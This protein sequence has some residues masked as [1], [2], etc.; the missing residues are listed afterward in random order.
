LK[1]KAARKGDLLSEEYAF[2]PGERET[3]SAHSHPEYQIGLGVEM[4][5]RY[6]YRGR[7]MTAPPMTLYLIHSGVTHDR[8]TE[9]SFEK[10]CSHRIL[11]AAPELI[12]G[13]AREVGWRSSELPFFP[14]FTINDA[15]L[16]NKFVALHRDAHSDCDR[17]AFDVAQTRFLAHLVRSFSNLG[18]KDKKVKIPPKAIK[19]V[20][21]YLDANFANAISLADLAR[22]GQVSKYHLCRTF[23]ES[24]GVSLHVYQNHLRLDRAKRL[25][26]QKRSI[27]DVAYELGFYD[28]SHFGRYFRNF[29]GVTPRMYSK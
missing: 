1:F 13:V 12:F 17:L 25:L 10:P 7:R 18:N 19:I 23:R 20:R 6:K 29:T 27:A 2:S 16:T 4:F 15:Q 22:I 3:W 9:T 28:Q 21:E 26:L 24:V 11:Y 8:G 14:S 5:K